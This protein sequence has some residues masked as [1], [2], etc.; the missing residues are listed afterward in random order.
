MKPT[1]TLATT[2]APDGSVLTLYR[3]DGAYMMV[4]DGVELMSTRRVHSEAQ[5]AELA[6]R[7]V[8]QSAAAAVLIGG[9]GF[10]FTLRAALAILPPEATVL[11]AELLADVITWNRRADWALAGASLDDP[12]V[13]VRRA[14]VGDVLRESAGQFD[15]IML[16]V[17]NGAESLTTGS[18]RRLYGEK[19]IR[20]AVAA[21]RPGGR[22]A[23]WSVDTEPAFVRA[24]KREGLGVVVH[25]VRSHA[26]SGGFNTVI[27]ATRTAR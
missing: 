21:L 1:E 3:H 26:T 24:L 16:D 27:V 5:L 6:C 4:V 18:N 14:D 10:G 12:R 17:D 11:V 2:T 7:P 13:T 25:K 15:A 9:L 19:G 20:T 23:Y 22:I 8:A